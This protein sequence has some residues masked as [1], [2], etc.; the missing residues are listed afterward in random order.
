MRRTRGFGDGRTPRKIRLA[1]PDLFA[2]AIRAGRSANELGLQVYVANQADPILSNPTDRQRPVRSGRREN[3]RP[4]RVRIQPAGAEARQPINDWQAEHWAAG[5]KM[6][7]RLGCA[8]CHAPTLGDV[9]GIYSDLLLHDMGED[10][11]DPAGAN[12]GTGGNSVRSFNVYYGGSTDV[13]VAVPRKARRQVRTPPLWDCRSKAPTCTTAAHR[14]CTTPSY[15]TGVKPT[16]PEKG[17][18][19]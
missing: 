9:A 1:R 2:Q 5:E 17:M 16:P 6:F 12:P 10:L 14:P 7:Y 3:K 19:P 8:D 13:F 18:P 11:A 4:D 15:A